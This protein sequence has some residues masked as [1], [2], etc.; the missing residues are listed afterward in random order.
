MRAAQP[1]IRGSQ[2]LLLSF[3]SSFGGGGI[4]QGSVFVC[5]EAVHTC[6]NAFKII[7][8]GRQPLALEGLISSRRWFSKEGK[9]SSEGEHE[10]DKGT[11][12]Q[13]NVSKKSSGAAENRNACLSS[14]SPAKDFSKSSDERNTAQDSAN[15]HAHFTD[16][17][18]VPDSQ[19]PPQKSAARQENSGN[20]EFPA[21]QTVCTLSQARTSSAL[22]WPS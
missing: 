9:K 1:F 12:A 16:C 8:T 11:K 4:T 20:G 3:R 22:T 18:H 21:Q 5:Q 13:Q 10:S 17:Q 19:T 2:C 15:Q 7:A 14:K 6:H